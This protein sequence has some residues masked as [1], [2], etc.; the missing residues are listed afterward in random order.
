MGTN[1]VWGQIDFKTNKQM[2]TEKERSDL[3]LPQEGKGEGEFD[4][5]S[6]K[7]ANFQL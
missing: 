5:G 2:N 4:E 1:S 3:W 6:Q 7:N